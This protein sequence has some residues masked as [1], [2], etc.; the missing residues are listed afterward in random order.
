MLVVQNFIFIKFCFSFVLKEKT[1]PVIYN[2]WFI[3]K[4]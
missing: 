2:T 3:H 1:K 4:Y